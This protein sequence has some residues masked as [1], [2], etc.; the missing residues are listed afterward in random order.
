MQNQEGVNAWG[1]IKRLPYEDSFPEVYRL[2][3]ISYT[4]AV[5]L[6]SFSVAAISKSRLLTGTQ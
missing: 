1:S 6:Q 4:G 3:N 2:E 5:F